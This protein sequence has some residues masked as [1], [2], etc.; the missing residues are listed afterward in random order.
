[1]F[2]LFVPENLYMGDAQDILDD[3]IDGVTSEYHMTLGDCHGELLSIPVVSPRLV[4]QL[5]VE[6]DDAPTGM[7][8]YAEDAYVL[9][10]NVRGVYQDLESNES[11]EWARRLS[12]VI[13]PTDIASLEAKHNRECLF[14]FTE[15]MYFRHCDAMERMV[16]RVAREA[17]QAAL[18]EPVQVELNLTP[19]PYTCVID[20][21]RTAD[22]EIHPALMQ[23]PADAESIVSMMAYHV[24]NPEELAL[25]SEREKA[26]IQLTNELL[27]AKTRLLQAKESKTSVK[28]GKIRESVMELNHNSTVARAYIGERGCV[29]I[30]TNHLYT[31]EAMEDGYIRDIGEMYITIPL[32]MFFGATSLS[33]NITINNLTRKVA[34][35]GDDEANMD[36]GHVKNGHPCFGSAIEP[37]SYYLHSGDVELLYESIHRFIVEPDETDG[38][39]CAILKFPK[40]RRE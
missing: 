16:E 28:V 4:L 2:T 33:G 35:D 21:M 15:E 34:P 30:N 12:S 13:E 5:L 31:R 29:C 19:A 20:Q 24:S 37:I 25:V 22:V 17:S 18:L 9:V 39:G 38:W 40:A 10:D 1:M 32:E 6:H 11:I 7:V 36:C 23:E 26:V 8:K 3:F 14:G 27:M